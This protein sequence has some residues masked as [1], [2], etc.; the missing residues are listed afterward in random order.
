[1]NHFY[2][3]DHPPY[4]PKL[5]PIEYVFCELA[6]ELS[7]KCQRDWGLNI[8]RA[9]IY[10]I[11]SNVGLDGRLYSIFVHYGYQVAN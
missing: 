7:R 9:Y 6:A 3:V 11:L 1:M 8:I 4:R 5:A 2:S 10:D